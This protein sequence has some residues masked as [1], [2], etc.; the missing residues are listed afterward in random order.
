MKKGTEI[1]IV[2]TDKKK[3]KTINA[4]IFRHSLEISIL[5]M[6]CIRLFSALDPK[7]N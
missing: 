2:V 1:V 5:A 4:G 3:K 6:R 7:S